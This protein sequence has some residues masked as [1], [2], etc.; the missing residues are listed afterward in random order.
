M[1]EKLG[2][3][4]VEEAAALRSRYFVRYHSTLKALAVAA[5]EGQLP[6]LPDGSPR[7]TFD[8]DALASYWA[9]ACE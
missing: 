6:P 5:E 4:T 3:K 8:G 2:F 9:E 7:T 1:V